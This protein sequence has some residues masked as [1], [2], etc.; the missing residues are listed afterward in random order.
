MCGSCSIPPGIPSACA[1]RQ[2]DVRPLRLRGTPNICPTFT[3]W[4]HD[5]SR[6]F[7]ALQRL[8]AV[9]GGGCG[10]TPRACFWP[11]H[12]FR[13]PE[14]VL[15]ARPS[16]EVR[17]RGAARRS[18]DLVLVGRPGCSEVFS[19]T[20]DRRRA[21]SCAQG[22]PCR[23]GHHEPPSQRSPQCDQSH[24]YLSGPSR[25]GHSPAPI[26]TRNRRTRHDHHVVSTRPQC[27][28]G[29]RSSLYE[30]VQRLLAR[31]DELSP[32]RVHVR[33]DATTQTVPATLT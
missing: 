12:L 13:S 18:T 10:R 2:A 8:A 16:V 31:R 14:R 27:L 1:A 20:G 28:K 25:V 29:I 23:R 4:M 6:A 22:R 3:G 9:F 15:G 24:L 21:E 30:V 19:R 7:C 33:E 26:R 11:V 17:P 32:F 5:P